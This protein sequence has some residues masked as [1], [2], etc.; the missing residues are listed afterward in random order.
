MVEPYLRKLLIILK[1]GG[2]KGQDAAPYGYTQGSTGSDPSRTNG[3][4]AVA[5]KVQALPRSPSIGR[6]D[7]PNHSRRRSWAATTL[8]RRPSR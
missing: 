6:R 5:A 8:G 4:A 3:A 7:R 2:V 1:T